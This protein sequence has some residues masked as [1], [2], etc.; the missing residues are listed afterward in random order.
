MASFVNASDAVSA[1][2]EIE[3]R[4]H[5]FYLTA[6]A[7]SDT[8]EKKEFFTFM[9]GEE[10]KHEGLFAGMLKR[11]GGLSLPETSD[12]DEYMGYVEA[13]LDSHMLF[14]PGSQNTGGNPYNLAIQFEKDT[15]IYFMA[16]QDLVPDNEK[17]VVQE[18]INEEKGHIRLIAK[19]QKESR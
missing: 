6:A 9:A 19:K 18:I 16:L 4:G 13:A 3:K 7:D 17:A 11:I 5:R 14:T 2:V 1:A 12:I 8:P 10:Q 15:I